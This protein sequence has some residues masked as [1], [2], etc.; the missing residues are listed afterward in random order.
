MTD[1]TNTADQGD[2][3][4]LMTLNRAPVNAMSAAFLDQIEAR[5]NQLEADNSV[6]A[7]VIGSAFKVLSAGLDLKEAQAFS[8]DDQTAIVDN[9]N[10]AFAALFRFPKPL[11]VA[12]SGSAIAGGLFLV[13]AADYAVTHSAARFG[14]AEVRVGADF[15][16]GPLE[17]ARATLPPQAL[18]RL[19]LSGQPVTANQAVSYGFID[20]LAKADKILPQAITA[21]RSLAASPPHTYASVKA[22]IRKPT[23]D[24]IEAAIASQTDPAR[25]GW[26]TDETKAAMKAMIG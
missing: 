4:T 21:A 24:I 17:I 6:R 9:L 3:I 20:E 19:M 15:P 2:G 22:Q 8:S 13:L 26:F 10:S 25:A 23:L 16:I 14:L 11:V 18:R 7:V 1:L 12:A 5:L